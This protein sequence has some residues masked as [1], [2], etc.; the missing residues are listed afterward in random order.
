MI[1][2]LA[3]AAI[4]IV[5]AILFIVLVFNCRIPIGRYEGQ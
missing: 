4:S 3:I 1:L 5:L 2:D